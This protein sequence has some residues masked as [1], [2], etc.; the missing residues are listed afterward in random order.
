MLHP[1]HEVDGGVWDGGGNLSVSRGG[2]DRN[3]D[4]CG[5]GCGTGSWLYVLVILMGVIGLI[6]V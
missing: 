1:F 2:G 6:V 5:G 4:S 3:D